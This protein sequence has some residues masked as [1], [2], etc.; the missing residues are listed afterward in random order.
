ME[1][2]QEITISGNLR[3]NHSERGPVMRRV[4]YKLMAILILVCFQPA[5]GGSRPKDLAADDRPSTDKPAGSDFSQQERGLSDETLHKLVNRQQDLVREHSSISRNPN[6]TS[7][8]KIAANFPV[9]LQ[10]QI[11]G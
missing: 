9:P 3:R 2:G 6:L 4:S 1:R 7:E 10:D 8:Q 11:P 5:H